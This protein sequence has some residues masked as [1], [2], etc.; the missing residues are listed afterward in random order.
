M[1]APIQNQ[2]QQQGQTG[3]MG[4]VPG[5]PAGSGQGIPK[6]QQ[7]TGYTNLSTIMGANQGNQLGQ[8]VAG[9]IEQTGQQ[10]QSALNSGV[11]NFN[12]NSAANQMGTQDQKQYVQNTLGNLGIGA[13]GQS[14]Y[15]SS[16]GSSQSQLVPSIQSPSSTDVSKFQQYMS[17]QYGGPTNI[18]N[19]NAIQNQAANAQQQGQEAS[20]TGGRQALLQQYAAN[21]ST[22]YGQGAQMLDTALLGATGGKQLGQASQAV[23]GL[24]NQVNSVESAA[25]QQAQQYQNQAQ[26]FGQAV[27]GQV[28][29][30]SANVYNPAQ[31][32][33]QQFNANDAANQANEQ[34]Q[35]QAAQAGYL[36]DSAA[37]VLGLSNGQ[38]TYGVNVGQYIGYNPANEQ[39]SALNVMNQP[40]QQQYSGLQQ[41]MGNAPVNYGP[42]YQAGQTTYNQAGLQS[43]IAG[44]QSQLQP[45][46]NNVQAL[47]N[48]YNSQNAGNSLYGPVNYLQGQQAGQ[49]AGVN[50]VGP[51]AGTNTGQQYN[52]A[53]TAYQNLNNQ[54]GGNVDY[55]GNTLS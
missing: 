25:Q 27:T 20:T 3:Q 5:M 2:G 6:S 41:L 38:R 28:Q 42:A 40:Q 11:Q 23:S 47:Q 54:M 21:P 51:Y 33:A 8:A 4:Q 44:Q 49:L 34:A 35:V 46:I 31:Q 7:G 24:T 32:Q 1:T 48:L 37:Q 22:A 52:A 13:N 50:T 43:A 19:I 55:T 10:A 53:L 26:G 18:A 15:H 39:A 14:L 45:Y 30:A 29:G 36:T 9:G 17:G 16:S 12:K